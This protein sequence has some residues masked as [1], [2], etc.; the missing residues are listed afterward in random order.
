MTHWLPTPKLSRFLRRDRSS[1]SKQ[2]LDLT[3]GQVQRESAA[4]PWM[5]ALLVALILPTE[6]SI[7]LGDLRLSPYRILILLAFVP[8]LDKFIKGAAGKII[9]PD[10]L[11]IA[12]VSWA[13][14]AYLFRDGPGEAIESGGVYALEAFGAYMIA[15]TC[16]RSREDFIKMGRLLFGMV[17]LF[18]LITIPE[19]LT[20]THFVHDIFGGLLG[21]RPATNIEGR[22]GFAR[23]YGPYDHPILYGTMV[24][25]VFSIVW[26]LR[27]RVHD[28]FGRRLGRGFLVAIAT[29]TSLSAACL[30]ALFLQASLGLYRWATARMKS[31]WLL[32]SAGIG[33]FYI[34][35]S[36]ISD[37][38][39]LKALLWYLTFDR[40]TASYRIAIWDYAG[41]NIE[42]KPWIG[43]GMEHWVRPDW[44][45]ESVDSFWLV[46]SLSF[47]LPATLFLVLAV[48]S[49]AWR[50]GRQHS[51]DEHV[52][53]LRLAW[54]FTILGM[55]LIAFT[56]HYWNNL[57]VT[58][59]FML[60]A[61][62]WLL[63]PHSIPI[64]REVLEGK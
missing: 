24:A 62:S 41:D 57:F 10:L 33:V 19:S 53:R 55:C 22:F 52:N 50:A 23:A 56:V 49:M 20:H 12:H 17:I 11:M 4:F 37:R 5:P 21:N 40:Q 13:I 44:M 42:A 58:F 51:S 18:A 28:G 54:V 15:R 27:P 31:R 25:A 2:V 14:L 46:T 3:E 38:T 8:C 16:I 59:F 47:G 26:N 29:F 34:L 1:A 61:G 7:Y 48:L 30:M 9:L 60:G 35:V 6:L 39:G 64:Q 36:L 43:I 32:L 45:A 63:Q